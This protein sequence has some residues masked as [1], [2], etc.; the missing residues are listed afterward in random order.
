MS[1]VERL[2]AVC[3]RIGVSVMTVRGRFVESERNI[4]TRSRETKASSER[5]AQPGVG[6]VEVLGRRFQEGGSADTAGRTKVD[7]VELVEVPE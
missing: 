5:R 2:P 6:H 7:P 3:A 4:K 1:V